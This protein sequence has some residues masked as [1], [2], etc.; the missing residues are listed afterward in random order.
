MKKIIGLVFLI[1]A[2]MLTTLFAS[3]S[4][5]ISDITKVF[6]KKY[7]LPIYSTKYIP[8]RVAEEDF[9]FAIKTAKSS[10]KR[11]L[12]EIGGDWCPWC[13]ALDAFFIDNSDLKSLMHDNYVVVK[14]YRGK[15]NYNSNFLAQFP[16][17]LGTPHFFVLKPDGSL[18]HSQGT[19][20]LEKGRSYDKLKLQTFLKRWIKK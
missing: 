5:K 14:I 4:L 19:E 18:L 15:E 9:K 1:V 2:V 17:I 6:S 13:N 3:G 16:K 8:N 11:I 7:D 12:M 20:V 10:D